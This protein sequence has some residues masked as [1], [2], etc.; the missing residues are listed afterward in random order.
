[1]GYG[2]VHNRIEDPLRS[3]YRDE[4][5]PLRRVATQL[6]VGE[7]TVRVL[8]IEAGIPRRQTWTVPHRRPATGR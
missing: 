6:G 7:S 5:W 2:Y 8:L 1:M 4:K 3:L